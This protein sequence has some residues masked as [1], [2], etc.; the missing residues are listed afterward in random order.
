MALSNRAEAPSSGMALAV[1]VDIVQDVT[2][3]I[4]EKGKVERGWLGVGIGQRAEDDRTVIASV[5]PESPA[6]LAK[7]RQGDI[8]LQIGD[9]GVT[10]PDV[11]VAEIRKR[12]PGQ[13][14]ALGIERD[15]KP[16]EVK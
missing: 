14:G 6:E 3:Q 8:V 16:M 9:R 7:L 13:D 4:K 1:P 2:G 15:G 11:L 5:D 12:K 10:S